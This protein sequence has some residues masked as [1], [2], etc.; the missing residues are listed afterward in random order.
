MLQPTKKV[1]SA[2]SPKREM[3]RRKSNASGMSRVARANAKVFKKTP[4]IMQVALLF[5][6]MKFLTC[7]SKVPTSNFTESTIAFLAT[8]GV[9]SALF[10]GMFATV[11]TAF[12]EQVGPRIGIFRGARRRS[13]ATTR[14]TVE[15][16]D[17]GYEV[18]RGEDAHWNLKMMS[19]VN[20]NGREVYLTQFDAD[21]QTDAN[22]AFNTFELNGTTSTILDLYPQSEYPLLYSGG[23]TSIDTTKIEAA[24]NHCMQ[25]AAWLQLHFFAIVALLGR[26][27]L[28]F[29]T[30]NCFV[31]GIL[32]NLLSNVDETIHFKNSMGMKMW[33]PLGILLLGV[34]CLVVGE[35]SPHAL[36]CFFLCA[37]L[38]LLAPLTV[39]HFYSPVAQVFL[40]GTNMN[41]TV[42]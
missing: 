1:A 36:R 11:D 19:P 27:A 22:G 41:M 32:V 28:L 24:R 4:S 23:N 20:I 10:M 17:H 26:M 16:V 25:Y 21:L 5:G 29:A 2:L 13:G 7:N 14:A 39:P 8:V 37:L 15:Y 42:W 31:I 18:A 6:T 33:I 38:P 12:E 40:A 3:S 9:Q 35:V 30:L 34:I